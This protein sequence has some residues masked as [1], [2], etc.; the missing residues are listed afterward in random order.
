MA[1]AY[2]YTGDFPPAEVLARF[3]NWDYALDEEGEDGQDETTIKP[4]D[5]QSFITEWTAFTAADA[6]SP[7]GTK[8][9]ALVELVGGDV[10][11]VTVFE[12]SESWRVLFDLTSQTWQPFVE[13]WLP[14]ADR[15]RS[16][17]LS[18]KRFFPLRVVTKLPLGNGGQPWRMEIHPDGSAKLWT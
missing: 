16:V 7:G 4:E 13:D 6:F 10:G 14:E 18:D 5:E 12:A 9:V 2:R 3:P 11:G 1:H 8:F 15:C 17:E